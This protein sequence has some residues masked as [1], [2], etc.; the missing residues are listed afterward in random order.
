PLLLQ[1][2]KQEISRLLVAHFITPVPFMP[3]LSLHPIWH[4]LMP[5][6]QHAVG[7]G[8]HTL[9]AFAFFLM[10]T[11]TRTPGKPFARYLMILQASITLVDLNFGFLASPIGLYPIPG[12]LCN[13]VLCTVFGLNGHY[14]ITLMFITVAFVAVSVLFCF[15]FKFIIIL[16]MSKHQTVPMINRVFFRVIILV[17]YSIPC[18]IHMTIRRNYYPSLTYLFEN[19][20][21]RTF[22]YDLTLYPANTIA[23]ATTTIVYFRIM[24]SA[25]IIAFF[26]VFRSFYLLSRQSSTMSEKT[27]KMQRTLMMVVQTLVPLTIQLTPLLVYAYSMIAVALTP[28]M[29]NCIFCFQMTH[30]FVHTAIVILTTPSYREPLILWLERLAQERPVC[31][32][33]VTSYAC[34]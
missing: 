8:T 33:Y 3:N 14:G 7:V 21:Y 16:A 23:L 17:I 5:T 22:V 1:S 19:P 32:S 13:G 6:Y 28:D 18:F 24:I 12:G 2:V 11:K 30:A 4:T 31:V 9:S 27:R 20:N 29:N 26:L 15:H 10:I 25:I 34:C